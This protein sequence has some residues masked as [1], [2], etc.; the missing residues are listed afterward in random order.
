M[1]QPKT[2]QEA[3]VYFSDPDNC[4]AYLVAQ[5]WPDGAV[6]CPTCGRANPA[7]LKNQRKWQCAER[8]DRRQF[9]I[10]A[11]TI[12]EDSPISL[13]KWLL[14]VWMVTNCKNGVS[15][16]EIHR[17]IGVTQKTA[18]FMLHRIRLAM[19]GD[20]VDTFGGEVEVDETYI[21]GLARNMHRDRREKK[22][23]GRTGGAGKTA[24]FGLLERNK[25]GKTK[26]IGRVIPDAWKDEV[27]SIIRETVEPGSA[28]YS[29]EHGAYHSLGSEG[30]QHAFVRHAETYVDCAVHTNGIENFWSLLKRGIKGTYV[31]VEPFHMFR[32]VDEQAFRFNERFGDD[33]ERFKTVISQIVNKRVTYKQLTGKAEGSTTSA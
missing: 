3:I 27:R 30:F 4:I 28:I 13:D 1:R 9:S 8:H 31:S 15:S 20:I 29:D 11:G 26:V 12:F 23:H 7:Y 5:R 33:G 21:G 17:D 18:W 2:L 16:Y 32:Y 6:K 10:K 14:A 19:Q 22:I 24:V 25:D